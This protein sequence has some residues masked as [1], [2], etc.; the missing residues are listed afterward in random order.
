MAFAGFP[1]RALDFY[2]GLAADNT[3]AYWSDHRAVYDECVAGP[4]RALLDALGPEFG[5]A[6]VFR[7]YRDVRFSRDKSPYKTQAAAV[8]QEGSDIGQGRYVAL[9]AA[10]LEAGGG[11]HH[12][13]PDQVRRWREAVAGDRWGSP[14]AAEV[15]ALRAEGWVV[16]GEQLV[17]VPKPWD[18]GHPRA[19][20]LRLKTVTAVLRFPPEPWLSTPEALDRVAGAWRRVGPLLDWLGQHVGPSREPSRR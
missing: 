12:T 18:A 6:K 16:E 1:E 13:A 19:D 14:L 3:K 5:E 20:L 17:R 8:V 15:A 2:E 7:P 4:L 11:F 9:S 10:G